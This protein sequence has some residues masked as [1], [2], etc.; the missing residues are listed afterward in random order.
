M[1]DNTW[2][3]Q[4][5]KELYDAYFQ[6]VPVE[7]TILVKF[8][9]TSR[10]R[11]GSIIAKPTTGYKLPVTYISINALFK[12]EIVPE[13]VIQATLLHEFV[14]YTHGFHS[15][16]PQKHRY[17]H[18]GG[19]VNKEIRAR[20]AGAILAQQLKWIKHEYRDFLKSKHLL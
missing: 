2:L 10:T 11:F 4:Q 8:G 14:H 9:R 16:I 15:P 17:P 20:G 5:M 18:Q 19:I 12:D 7:N 6:D 1:R 13:F 3:A